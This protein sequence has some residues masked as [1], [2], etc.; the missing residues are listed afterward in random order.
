MK[1]ITELLKKINIKPNNLDYYFLAMTHSSYANENNLKSNERLEFL[2]DAILEH[3][4]SE[5]LFNNLP[6]KAEGELT[7]IRSQRVCEEALFAYAGY[8]DLKDYLML[9]KGEI[10]KGATASLIADSFEA[11]IGAIYLDQG[12]L[13]VKDFFNH[14]IINHIND[15]IKL[16]DY[17]TILQEKYASKKKVEYR[18]VKESGPAHRK[19]FISSCLID[20]K[21]YGIGYGKSK[22]ESEQNAAK[23]AY[24]YK[25]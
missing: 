11:L 3:L 5:Y 13:K 21:V 18:L 8:I 22:K 24:N 17:K 16:I 2:G 12:F 20:N 15:T 14:F 9:G 7:K 1:D 6:D 23:I 19:E 10:I 4:M 25:E